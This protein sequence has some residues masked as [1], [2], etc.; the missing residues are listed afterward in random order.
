MNAEKDIGGKETPA[1]SNPV[2]NLSLHNQFRSMDIAATQPLFNQEAFSVA[3]TADFMNNSNAADNGRQD[4]SR[5]PGGPGGMGA[6][7]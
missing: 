4:G 7:S 2:Q 5:A 3:A 1:A 6:N